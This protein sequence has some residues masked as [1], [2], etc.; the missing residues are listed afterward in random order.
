MKKEG[1]LR[2]EEKWTGVNRTTTDIKKGGQG[3]GEE[4][5]EGFL[6]TSELSDT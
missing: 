2:K 3:G 4:E 5:T 1:F 6:R